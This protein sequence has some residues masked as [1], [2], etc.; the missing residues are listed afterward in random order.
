MAAAAIPAALSAISLVAGLKTGVTQGVISG[1]KKAVSAGLKNLSE[2][3]L[4]KPKSGLP[5]LEKPINNQVIAPTI[6]QEKIQRSRLSAL[7]S[8]QARTGRASTLLTSQ[9]GQNNTFG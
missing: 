1:D 2:G 9:A 7:Q 4:N 6:N 3:D 8:L 5:K